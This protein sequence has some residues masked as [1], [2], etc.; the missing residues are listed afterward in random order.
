MQQGPDLF[1]QMQR[2]THS[3]TNVQIPG[4]MLL[5]AVRERPTEA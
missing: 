2:D 5:L 1:K 4:F 3:L